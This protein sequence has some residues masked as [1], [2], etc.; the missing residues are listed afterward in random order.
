MFTTGFMLTEAASVQLKMLEILV[1]PAE[2]HLESR[3]LPSGIS[4]DGQPDVCGVRSQVQQS[5]PPPQKTCCGV[6]VSMN[7]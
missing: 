6:L 1:C 2:L 5:Y 7:S 4:A 3:A